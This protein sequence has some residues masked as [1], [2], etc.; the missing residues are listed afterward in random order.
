MLVLMFVAG[1]LFIAFV[2]SYL[3]LWIVSPDV[4]APRAAPI[5]SAGWPAA[6]AALFVTSIAALWLGWRTLAQLGSRKALTPVFILAET[7]CAGA[8]VAIDLYAQWQAGLRPTS[9]SYA[10][11]VTWRALSL[12]NLSSRRN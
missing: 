8:A 9:A 6:S 12:G 4:W 2:F 5:P 7:L 11:M 1:S 10:A 3:Y